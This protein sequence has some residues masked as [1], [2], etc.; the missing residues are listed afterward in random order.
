MSE[1]NMRGTWLVTKH[2]IPHLIESGRKNR[3]PHILN[4]S[5]PP[6]IK[7]D[8]FKNHVT[9][10]IAKYNMSLCVLGWAAEFRDQGI[11]ANALWPITVIETAA[12]QVLD[13]TK[14]IDSAFGGNSRTPEIMA[15]AAHRILTKNSKEFSG[16]FV[17]DEVILRE[18]G[19]TEFDHYSTRPGAK[20]M[21]IDLFV[22]DKI[23][24]KMRALWE[25]KSHRT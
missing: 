18:H 2:A 24:N 3:N 12:L 10:S 5:P 15:D 25:A 17:I 1:I 22:D 11:A 23:V 4:L 20:D 9:Y 14:Q 16:N 13:S 21:T 8:W 7:E 19:Q 6:L